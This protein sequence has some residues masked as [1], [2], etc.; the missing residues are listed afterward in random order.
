MSTIDYTMRSI[1]WYLVMLS[2]LHLC[3]SFETLHKCAKCKCKLTQKVSFKYRKRNV[4]KFDYL[5]F[6]KYYRLYYAFNLV[7]SSFAQYVVFMLQFWN[8]AHI[9]Q[10]NMQSYKESF[11]LIGKLEPSIIRLFVILETLATCNMSV[12]KGLIVE[13]WF[14]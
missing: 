4:V 2:M 7:M 9:W 3:Y 1:W 11:I 5:Y 8:F 13:Y 6:H 10:K 14:A 12:F